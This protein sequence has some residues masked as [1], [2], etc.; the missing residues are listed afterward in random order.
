MR[1]TLVIT[2]GAGFLGSYF[3][4]NFSKLYSVVSVDI[5]QNNKIS[6]K[7]IKK[8][9]C[10][11]TNE[12]EV[13]KKLSFLKKNKKIHLINN[14]AIDSIPINSKGSMIKNSSMINQL[15]VS[16]EGPRIMMNLLGKLMCK[17]K[18]GSVVNIGSDLSIIAPNQN[19][20]KGAYKN[21]TKSLDYSVVK[22]GLIGLT[23]YY[24][25]LNAKYNVKVNMV[26]PAPIL[27]NQNKKLVH[28]IKNQI[29]MKKLAEKEDLFNLIFFLISKKSKFITGQ[30][31][32]VDGG[33]TII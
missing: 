8:I 25:S 26:S 18:Y 9:T 13:I 19:I 24:A 17:N 11:I 23:K 31:I 15:I 29:P 22:H 1:E 27:N 7:Y 14:A 28:N 32:L 6:N 3:C 16:F 33:R 30:N 5:K 4:D 10:D 2:G 12:K 20:Y 21:F